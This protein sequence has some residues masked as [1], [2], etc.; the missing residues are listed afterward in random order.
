MKVSRSKNVLRNLRSGL[1]YKAIQ[2]VFP[3]TIRSAI[4]HILGSE[5][6][7]LDSLFTSI[8]QVLNL[9][10]LG[11]SSAITYSM[12]KPIVDNDTKTICALLKFY[13]KFYRIIGLVIFGVGLAILPFL[14]FLIEGGTPDAVNIYILYLTYLINTVLS[15]ILFEYKAVILNAN[16]RNDIIS[17]IQSFVS[18]FQYIIQIIVL[19]VL[20]NYYLFVAVAC[21]GTI[22][23]NVLLSILAK[24]K[25]PEYICKGE[26]SGEQKRD[27]RKRVAGLMIYKVC[28]TTRNSLDSV[29]ISSMVGLTAVAIYSNY[30]TIMAAIIGVMGVFSSSVISSVGNSIVTESEEKNYRDMNKFNFL[31]MWFSGWLTVCMVCLYQPLMKLW[32]GEENM[33]PFGIAILFCIY[34]Y[35]LK[36]GDVRAIY[37]DARGLWYENRYRT[38]AE[39]VL[40][41]VLN[42]VLGHFFGVPGIIVA[43][44]ISLIIFGFAYSAKILFKHYFV[45]YK[46]SRFFLQHAIYAFVTGVVGIVTY[47]ACS[48][49]S[50][51]GILGLVLKVLVCISLPNLIYL[52]MYRNTK[53]YKEAIGFVKN[54]MFKKR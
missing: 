7:G 33:F 43:T 26:L 15:Y 44:L 30:Y 37:S 14:G 9:A 49:V 42:V 18:A 41:V 22:I 28:G 48:L 52:L 46:V 8:L 23:D 1:F 35:A 3:F 51:D 29:F 32:M 16:Q 45:H 4:I 19:V 34:F 12:Y 25:Y 21:I 47:L 27:I 5:Y 31:Y 10:E 6:L 11:F 38:I 36:M 13:R 54:I 24:K 39:S 40:N 2:V 50:F 20:K 53:I 17:N